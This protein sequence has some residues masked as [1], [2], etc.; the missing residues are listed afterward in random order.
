MSLWEETRFWECRRGRQE[1]RFGG[2]SVP[3]ETGVEVGGGW[4][5]LGTRIEGGVIVRAVAQLAVAVGM[6]MVAGLQMDLFR[7]RRAGG[8]EAS[9]SGA[10]WRGVSRSGGQNQANGS[11]GDMGDAGHDR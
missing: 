6:T 5:A 8:V 10:E 2:P 1:V 11:Y 9:N 4:F 3:A 7:H